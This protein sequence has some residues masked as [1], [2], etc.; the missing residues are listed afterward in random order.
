[1][2]PNLSTFCFK[3]IIFIGLLFIVDMSIGASFVSLKDIGLKKNPENMWLKTPFVVEKVNS[4][5]VIIG[6]SKASHHY[7]PKIIY[8]SL[9]LSAYNCGQDGCFFLCQNC[10]I[11]MMLDRYKP[12][13]IIWDIQPNSFFG[14]KPK[15]YQNFRYLSP[16]Y[17]IN[18]WAKDYI[19][20]ESAKMELRM[21]SKLFS[22]NSKALNYVFPLIAGSSKTERGYIALPNDGYKFPE[23]KAEKTEEPQYTSNK[24]YLNLLYTTLKRC[25][26]E[27]VDIQLFI[28][29]EY[30]Y[31]SKSFKDAVK[32]ISRI[33]NQNSVPF[34][35][36]HTIGNSNDSTLFK[37]TSHLNAKGAQIYTNLVVKELNIITSKSPIQRKAE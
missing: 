4:D 16:Y 8:D 10:V 33:A 24:K 30:N 13:M 9:G 31:E 23:K 35:N 12:K 17:H 28:S 32:D 20:S 27:N 2:K 19:D 21:Y 6:S 34:H 18:H 29:P 15:E 5:V 36:F 1:M 7:I 37:D 26:K 3:V 22:Y 25:K 14:D 11:N